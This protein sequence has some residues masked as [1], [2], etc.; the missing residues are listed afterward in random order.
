MKVSLDWL[1]SHIRLT[2]TP[3][4]L[5]DALTFAGIEVE[6]MQTTGADFDRVVVGHVL[7]RDPHPNADRLSICQVDVGGEQRRIVCGASNFQAGDKVLVALTGAVLPGDFK[8]KDSKIRGERSEGMMCSAK[9]LGLPGDEGGLLLL[10]ASAQPGTPLREVFARDTVWDLEITPNRPDLLSHRGIAREL[11]ALGHGVLEPYPERE[12]LALD[13]YLIQVFV[14]NGSDC[15]CYTATRI[16]GCGPGI[17]PPTVLRQLEAVGQR[18]I[19]AAV[20]ATN[21]LLMDI[22]QPMHVFDADRIVGDLRVRRAQEG[23]TLL[24]LDHRLYTLG[25]GDLVIADENGPVAL[26]GVI[27]GE[28]S[29]VTSSTTNILLEVASFDPALVRRTGRRHGLVTDSSYRFERQVDRAG[30]ERARAAAVACLCEWTGGQATAQAIAS[31]PAPEQ[32]VVSYRAARTEALAGAAL[33]IRRQERILLSLG[34][35]KLGEESGFSHWS[36]PSWRP[37]LGREADLAEEVIRVHGISQIP[38]K[39]SGGAAPAS[40]ADRQYDA[41]MTLKRKLVDLGFVEVQTSPLA[42]EGA[43]Q[44]ALLN[45]MIETEKALRPSLRE[46]LLRVAA[47]NLHQGIKS[48]RLFEVGRVFEAAGEPIH[49]ALLVAGETHEPHWREKSRPQDLFDLI[50]AA[51]AV[52]VPMEAEEPPAKQLAAAG[53][54]QPVVFGEATWTFNPKPPVQFQA[55]PVTPPVTRDVALLLPTATRALDVEEAFRAFP[56]DWI[57]SWSLF[58]LFVDPSGEKLAA[59]IRS[60]AYT[61]HYRHPSKTLTDKEVNEL[62]DRLKAHLAKSLDCRFRE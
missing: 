48:L 24:A 15:P 44:C 61:V 58:D 41:L 1:S 60:M 55:W 40:E 9:E 11:A 54:K 57:E 62:H 23:E 49:L 10:D 26:A 50:A 16:E 20:D 51:Q 38:S 53:I 19:G 46:G 30:I 13:E 29:A 31:T 52:G 42:P 43:E 2:C 36:V 27:G 22:G 12:M 32:M 3:D 39:L 25:Q 45:P 34:L 56:H 47:H 59:D 33:P 4:K 14:E 6:G 7:E 21:F 37:D 8:I 18:P 35:S 17:T 5:A 28:E